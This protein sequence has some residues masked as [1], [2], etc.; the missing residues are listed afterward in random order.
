MFAGTVFEVIKT[1]VRS[2]HE[3]SFFI[4]LFEILVM[5]DKHWPFSYVSIINLEQVNVNWTNIL[6]NIFP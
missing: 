5:L 4:Q 1:F 6:Q 2:F 3:G